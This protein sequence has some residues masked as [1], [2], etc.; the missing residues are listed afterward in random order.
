MYKKEINKLH[1]CPQVRTN[2]E[3]RQS[4]A[5][6]SIAKSLCVIANCLMFGAGVLDKDKIQ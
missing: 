3:S 1:F 4:E 5:L 2:Y 6:E